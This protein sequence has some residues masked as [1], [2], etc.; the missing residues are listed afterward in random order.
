MYGNGGLADALFESGMVTASSGILQRM[1]IDLKQLH[2][3]DCIRGKTRT[4]LHSRA[5][6]PII[7]KKYL[8]AQCVYST[9][10]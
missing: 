3:L 10:C 1:M 9:G 8:H 5:K 4:S 7:L 6:C 2:M